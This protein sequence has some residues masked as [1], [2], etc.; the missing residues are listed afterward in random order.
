MK[1]PY[2][3]NPEQRVLDS[4]PTR[5]ELAIRRRRECMG[6]ER[7][8]TTFEQVERPRL[9]VV[10]RDGAREEF[11]REKILAGMVTACRKRPVAHD[12]LREIAERI[13][14]DLFDEFEPEVTSQQVGDRVMEALLELDQVAFVRFASVYQDFESAS[15]FRSV[16]D[17]VRKITKKIPIIASGN[18]S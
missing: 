7:R 6:C 17:S 5:D 2:C 8:F 15:D 9:F 1:C 10:K 12:V 13:E 4:R 16:V 18:P 3:G 14:R 11:Y